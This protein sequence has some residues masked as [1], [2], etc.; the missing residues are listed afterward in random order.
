MIDFDVF[1]NTNVSDKDIL[2]CMAKADESDYY[3]CRICTNRPSCSGLAM[4]R[5]SQK[6]KENTK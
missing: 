2:G 5:L 6:L 3:L 1:N 4:K